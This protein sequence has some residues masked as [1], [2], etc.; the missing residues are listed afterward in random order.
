MLAVVGDLVEDVVV[1][2][3][4][5]LRAGTD[6]PARVFRSRG[7]SA[8]NVAVLAAR[9]VP[10]RFIGRVGD[11]PLGDQL[12][13]AMGA[14]GVDARVQ[15]GGRTG[16]IV[17]LVDADG[18]RT[19]LPDRAAAAELADVPAAWLDDVAVL[20]VPAYG[21][22]QVEPLVETATG[23]GVR[24][25]VDASSTA[26]L[27]SLGVDAFMRL[28]ARV[29]PSVLFANATE[30]AMLRLDALEGGVLVVKN[31][32]RP[33]RVVEPGGRTTEVPAQPVG[34]A[35]DSTGAG[36]A[37]AAAYLVAM[38]EGMPPPECARRGHQLASEVLTTPGAAQ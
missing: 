31:G 33:A 7:G 22:P 4:G 29:R 37:F 23:K 18:E 32:P 38:I 20:H 11:D 14:A 6:N 2:L 19:M 9:S 1:W 10:T 28:V 25:T 16:S 30:A 21:F 15:R 17:V 8:A 34:P 3:D 35:R 36:D 24:V 5:P 26:V 27:T 12:V 13:A